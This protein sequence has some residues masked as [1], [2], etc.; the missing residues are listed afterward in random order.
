MSDDLLEIRDVLIEN[1][2]EEGGSGGHQMEVEWGIGSGSGSAVRDEDVSRG[3]GMT[4]GGRSISEDE[5]PTHIWAPQSKYDPAGKG[6]AK[7]DV[8]EDMRVEVKATQVMREEIEELRA[9]NTELEAKVAEGEET[10]TRMR[11]RMGKGK[12]TAN[13]S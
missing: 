2:Q 12:T 6:Y 4:K 3:E 10:I 5:R 7:D 9:R 8:W 13:G 11:N 1:V